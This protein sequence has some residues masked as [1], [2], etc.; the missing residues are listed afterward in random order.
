MH[1]SVDKDFFVK[2]TLSLSAFVVK[3]KCFKAIVFIHQSA[4]I[5][6]LTQEWA[7]C[8]HSEMRLIGCP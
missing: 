8:Y 2:I 4:G 1:D 5:V 3:R 6:C 7:I